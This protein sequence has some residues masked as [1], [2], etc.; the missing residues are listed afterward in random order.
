[1]RLT[2]ADTGKEEELRAQSTCQRSEGFM[3]QTALLC[4]PVTKAWANRYRRLYDAADDKCFQSISNL[5]NGALLASKENRVQVPDSGGAW[6]IS[7]GR[8]RLGGMDITNFPRVHLPRAERPK[9]RRTHRRVPCEHARLPGMEAEAAWGYGRPHRGQ[10]T[11][12]SL[13][14]QRTVMAL[15]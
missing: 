4:H 14:W 12:L 3:E 15:C 11:L 5:I 2:L 8:M 13:R 9:H 1:M 7:T 6:G 10:G